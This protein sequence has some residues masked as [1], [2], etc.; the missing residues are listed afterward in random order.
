MYLL[1]YPFW[2]IAGVFI[3]YIIVY[4]AAL[5]TTYVIYLFLIDFNIIY[6]NFFQ[7]FLSKIHGPIKN[8]F[9][10][11]ISDYSNSLTY[12]V[13][14]YKII[15]CLSLNL[16]L[17]FKIRHIFILYVISSISRSRL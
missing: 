3:L 6:L 12:K 5:V 14:F 4:L 13:R 15:L 10:I 9:N 1:R 7:M 2:T 11:T 16:R 17:Q 8:I